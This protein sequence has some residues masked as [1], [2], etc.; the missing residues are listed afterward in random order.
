[1]PDNNQI[2][3]DLNQITR[4]EFHEF[5]KRIQEAKAGGDPLEADRVSGE[6][7]ERVCISWPFDNPISADGYLDLPM[8]D[9]LKVDRAFEEATEL[10]AQ[11]K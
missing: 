9:S 10:L 1:M 3:I 7:I 6:L 8:A 11:K 4:R 2:K 5:L